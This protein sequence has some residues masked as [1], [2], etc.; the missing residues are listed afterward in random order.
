MHPIDIESTLKT[1]KITVDSREQATEQS[2][3]RYADFGVPW[4]RGKLDFGDYSAAFTLPDGSK[5]DLREVCAV[6]RKMS[7]DELC[8]CYTHDRARFE[9]EFE[10]AKAVNAKIYLLIEDGSFRKAYNGT[11]KSQMKPQALIASIFAWLARYNCQ[12]I[13]AEKE[14]SGKIIKEILYREAKEFLQTLDFS[15]EP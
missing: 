2:K 11:Y 1:M 10:R 8:G 13:M 12:I 7:I 3:R 15:G 4:E 9:R 14:L 6:E 5:F